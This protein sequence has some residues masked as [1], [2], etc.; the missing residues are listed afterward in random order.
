MFPEDIKKFVI[1]SNKEKSMLKD[2][3]STLR[4]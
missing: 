1:E 2:F 3:E 4:N